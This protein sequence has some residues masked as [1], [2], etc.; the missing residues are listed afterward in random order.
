MTALIKSESPAYKRK[1]TN[2]THPTSD[3]S[4]QTPLWEFVPPNDYTVPATQVRK[5]AAEAWRSFQQILRRKDV[6]DTP[7]KDEQDLHALPQVRLEH[8]VPPLPWKDAAA[9]LDAVLQKW[10]AAGVSEKSVKFFIGQPFSG[11][12][13]I[14]SLLGGRHQAIEI[15]PPSIEQILS[16]DESWFDSWPSSATFW[17]LPKLEYCYLRHANGL[18]LVRRLLSLAAKGQLGKG[19]IGS[20]SWAWAYLQRIFPLPQADA[21]T[22]QAFDANRLQCLLYGLMQSQ[23]K[24]E[25]HCYNALNGQEITGASGKE[26]QR[27]QEFVELAAHCRGNVAI[28]TTYWRERLRYGPD[29]DVASGDEK[30]TARTGENRSD[31]HVWVAGMPPDPE[32]P[33]GNDEEFLLL[34][35]AMMLHGGLPEPLLDD[36]MPFSATRCRGLLVQLQQSGIVHCAN[37]R[38]QVRAMAY[39][40]IRRLLGAR[41]YLTDFF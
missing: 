4:A 38:W 37:G 28:A 18:D 24:T 6:A 34:L 33:I 3:S 10:T 20:D 23:S 25:I 32:L 40:P 29:E 17:V 22:L 14:V 13:E 12:A 39:I 36:L 7:F 5:A 41:D 35:H 1:M 27:Q 9:A 8:L 31:E 30:T 16:N 19:V 26:K 2:Q 11:H 15:M 21:I